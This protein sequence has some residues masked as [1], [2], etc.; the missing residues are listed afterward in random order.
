MSVSRTERTWIA[1][2]IV[3]FAIAYTVLAVFS[4]NSYFCSSIRS[5][6]NH[7]LTTARLAFACT[8]WAL[9]ICSLVSLAVSNKLIKPGLGLFFC[10]VLSGTGFVSIPFWIYRGYGSFLFENTWADVSCFFTEGYGMV[11]PIFVA[12]L[13]CA[14]T[15][16]CEWVAL[17]ALYASNWRWKK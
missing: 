13:L 2:P 4:Y 12:P 16:W 3:Y 15:L 9:V 8:A 14:A 10:T 7:A 11:F 1:L 6:H 5:G 17:K